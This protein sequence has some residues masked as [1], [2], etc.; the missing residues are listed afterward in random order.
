MMA[1]ILCMHSKKMKKNEGIG[2]TH[3]WWKLWMEKEGVEEREM[4]SR[5]SS[6][7]LRLWLKKSRRNKPYYP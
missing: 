6:T 4:M 7:I 5:K 2:K 3:G 1:D